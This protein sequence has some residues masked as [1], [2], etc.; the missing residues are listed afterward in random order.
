MIEIILSRA[1][2]LDDPDRALLTQ[3]YSR[4][5]QP[6]EIASITGVSLRQVHRRI[7]TLTDRLQA[8][9]VVFVLRHCRFWSRPLATV[10]VMVW[11]RKRTM[12]DT[13]EAM[14]VSLH[15]V[16]KYAQAV[17]V[18]LRA[19]ED[20][21]RLNENAASVWNETLQLAL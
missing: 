19:E 10:A 15:R 5:V 16:R 14:G 9:E 7:K 11:V 17:Q 3:I 20:R 13:A 21:V 4:G 8:P 18:L 6:D 2:H 12:R 1:E